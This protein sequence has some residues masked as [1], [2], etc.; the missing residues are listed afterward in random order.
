MA[1]LPKTIE[2]RVKYEFELL[3]SN[4]IAADFP[5]GYQDGLYEKALEHLDLWEKEKIKIEDIYSNRGSSVMIALK[6]FHRDQSLFQKAKK[7][8]TLAEQAKRPDE[9]KEGQIDQDEA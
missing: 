8:T 7:I 4:I 1:K 9:K 3:K 6:Y 5:S 2:N